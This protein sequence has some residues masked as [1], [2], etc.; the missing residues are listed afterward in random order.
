VKASKL[1]HTSNKQKIN[2]NLHHRHN[3]SKVD[4]RKITQISLIYL[5]IGKKRAHDL[6]LGS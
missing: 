2:E 5:F 1:E 6:V 4:R 3:A